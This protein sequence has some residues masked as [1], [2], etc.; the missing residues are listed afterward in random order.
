MVTNSKRIFGLD[1]LRSIAI[2]LVLLTHTLPLLDPTTF[3]KFCVYSGYYG[4]EFFFVLSGFL[5]GTILLK[6]HNKEEVIDFSDIKVFWIRRWFRTLPNYYLVFFVYALLYYISKHINVLIHIKYISYLFFLQ[7]SITYQPNDFFP[8]AWSLSIEEW[9]YL[10]FPLVLFLMTRIFTKKKSLSFL[11]TIITI[12]VIEI[13]T[14]FWVSIN[15][16]N[17]WD[18]G[19]RKMMPLRLDSIGIGVLVAYIK[20]YAPKLWNINANILALSG[21]IMLISLTLY[22]GGDYVTYFDPVTW[23]H[24]FNPGVFLETI[25][26]TLISFS[27]ALVIPW[28]Y[29]INVKETMLSNAVT[30]ISKISYSIYLTHFLIILVLSHIFKQRLNDRQFGII[31]FIGVWVMTIIISALQYRYF[32]VKMTALRNGISR[33]QA[34]IKI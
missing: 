10:L 32:E 34:E 9:F 4:V 16:N 22:F 26:F 15:L 3:S 18:E 21:L 7:N 13:I 31:L 29:R 23:D 24:G 6:I 25:F 5:I 17:Y 19:F 1:L 11:L 30:F 8:I 27:I 14:R 33:K 28:L 12:I 20:Y 2:I